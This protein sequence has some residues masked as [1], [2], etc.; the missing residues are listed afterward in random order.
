MVRVSGKKSPTH[1]SATSLKA[2]TA[3]TRKTVKELLLGKV[4]TYITVTTSTTREMVMERCTGQMVLSTRVTGKKEY[5]TA[6]EL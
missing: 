3:L 6:G 1:Q 5:S 4:E 2:I